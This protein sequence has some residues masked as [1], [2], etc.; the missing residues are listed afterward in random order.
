MIVSYDVFHLLKSYSGTPF[1]TGRRRRKKLSGQKA[2]INGVLEKSRVE[3]TRDLLRFAK[4]LLINAFSSRFRRASQSRVHQTVTPEGNCRPVKTVAPGQPSL[5][6]S[7]TV[8][9][10]LCTEIDGL[11]S[12][13]K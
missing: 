6:Q 13:M 3:I 1:E 10:N 8:L 2:L 7:A 5:G 4:N 9:L 11:L 12:N